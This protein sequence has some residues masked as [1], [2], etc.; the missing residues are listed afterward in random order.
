MATTH[1]NLQP[2]A[3]QGFTDEALRYRA[4]ASER[5]AQGAWQC[6]EQYLDLAESAEAEA[7][8]C[9]TLPRCTTPPPQPRLGR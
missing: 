3:H 8:A 2:S 7:L 1:S 9:L 6:V 5:A 4:V